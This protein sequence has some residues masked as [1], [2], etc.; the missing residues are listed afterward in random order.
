MLRC[1]GRGQRSVRLLGHQ[2]HVSLFLISYA[3]PSISCTEVSGSR[4]GKFF[5]VGGSARWSEKPWPTEE[6]S[7]KGREQQGTT[8]NKRGQEAPAAGGQ[9]AGTTPAEGA[10]ITCPKYNSDI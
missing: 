1:G 9:N 7:G 4:H 5:F 2:Y 8:G 6:E 3:S 10:C